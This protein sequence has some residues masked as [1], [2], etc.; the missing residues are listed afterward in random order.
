VRAGPLAFSKVSRYCLGPRPVPVIAV[1][2][3]NSGTALAWVFWRRPLTPERILRDQDG[4]P[5]E[6]TSGPRAA[7]L[8]TA[9]IL[10]RRPVTGGVLPRLPYCGLRRAGSLVGTPSD[11]RAGQCMRTAETVVLAV[12]WRAWRRRFARRLRVPLLPCW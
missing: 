1:P 4:Q 11:L 9:G 3:P 12:R 8:I 2:R 6:D 5:P 7:E 10:R